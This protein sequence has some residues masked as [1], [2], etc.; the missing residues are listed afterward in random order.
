MVQASSQPVAHRFG[1]IS[2]NMPWV[3][4]EEMPA[5]CGKVHFPS[6]VAAHSSVGALTG[7][8]VGV[9]TGVSVGVSTGASVGVT[10][11]ASV[12]ISTGDWT[13][14]SSSHGLFLVSPSPMQ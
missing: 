11:G 7:N 12:V 9:S 5:P 4:Q 6:I 13:E 14:V 2:S 1:Y 8:S 10:T 3:N